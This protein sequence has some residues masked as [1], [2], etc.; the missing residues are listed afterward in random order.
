VPR[1]KAVVESGSCSNNREF[2][3]ERAEC[4]HLHKTIA[5]ADACGKKLRGEH[6]EGGRWTCSAQWY[7]YTIHDED[8]RK[9]EY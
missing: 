9:V 2:W 8:G 4:G 6:W 5:A 3:E 7:N 1:Y